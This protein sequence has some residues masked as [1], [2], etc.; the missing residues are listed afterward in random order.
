MV[1]YGQVKIKKLSVADP[2]WKND[3][4]GINIPI[5]LETNADPQL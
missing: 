3:G 5:L 4:S 1:A 2:G